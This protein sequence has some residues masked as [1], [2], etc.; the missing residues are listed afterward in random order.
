MSNL[1][2]YFYKNTALTNI[3]E[4]GETA[5]TGFNMKGLIAT[6]NHKKITSGGVA[7]IFKNNTTEVLLG[8]T[9]KLLA[10]TS[11]TST[12]T[13]P[14]WVTSCKVK[15][16]SKDGNKGA[17]GNKGPDGNKGDNAHDHSGGE[18]GIGGTGGIGGNGGNGLTVV[19]GLDNIINIDSMTDITIEQNNTDGFIKFGDITVYD[20][21]IGNAGQRGNRGADGNGASPRNSGGPGGNCGGYKSQNGKAGTK[22]DDGT[23]GDNGTKGA[24]G[25]TTATNVTKT[26]V[27]ASARY[28]EVYGFTN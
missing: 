11:G 3:M 13:K 5:I 17:N 26:I 21:V 23:K 12:I 2:K 20:G 27:S 4:S 8:F 28:G 7:S 25:Y 1:D 14:G 24:D 19:S 18:P 6:E 10:S 16:V 15:L 22:G 9:G